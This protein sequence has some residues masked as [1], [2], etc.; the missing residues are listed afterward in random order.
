MLPA[1]ATFSQTVSHD[2]AYY[3]VVPIGKSG[4]G[5]LGDAGKF[6]SLGKK[7]I[8][9]L[10]DDGAVRATVSFAPNE[11]AVQLHG[12]APSLP[13]ITATEG[14]VSDIQYDPTTQ[15]FTATV[16]PGPNGVAHVEMRPN[17][18]A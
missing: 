10:S 8:S 2:G 14:S 4:I 6:V 5:F 7:R 3:I 9:A 16:A 15:L 1:G 12:Y 11:P 13:T 17:P 18:G